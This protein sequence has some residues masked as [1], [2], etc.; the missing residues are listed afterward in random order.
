[1]GEVIDHPCVNT[2]VVGD[3]SARHAVDEAAHTGRTG[4]ATTGP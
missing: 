2:Y 3:L 4:T 1:M